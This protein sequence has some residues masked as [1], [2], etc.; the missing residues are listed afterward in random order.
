MDVYYNGDHS[1]QF[2]DF[3]IVNE[4][5]NTQI[6]DSLYVDSWKDFGLIPKQLPVI[7]PAPV[8]K[9]S[10]EV[11]GANS[12]IDLTEVPRGFPTYQNR[13]GSL[14]F[15]V[16]GSDKIGANGRVEKYF[17]WA[18]VLD[19]I[20]EHLHGFSMKM[21]LTDDPNNYYYGRFEVNGWNPGSHANEITINYDLDPY[22]YSIF[23]TTEEWLWN[24]FDFIN[25]T[26]PIGRENFVD[27]DVTS[28]P[29]IQWPTDIVGKMPVIPK[30]ILSGSTNGVDIAVYNSVYD[31]WSE[32]VHIQNGI[33]ESVL[34][35]LCTPK[36]GSFT[37][38]NL[39][40]DG[41]LSIDFRPGR[42]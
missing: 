27:I 23:T 21:M 3:R 15:Y 37:Q 38:I 16:D 10:V 18:E 9:K 17:N 14:T 5:Q 40:G 32:T 34:L 36:V 22:K 11:Y 29:S 7:A 4:G 2:G 1:V 8:V 28:T 19:K 6:D 20:T 26:I 42:L 35:E 39:S 24:P 12:I 30:F 25:G 41:L 13:T 31:E 33:N